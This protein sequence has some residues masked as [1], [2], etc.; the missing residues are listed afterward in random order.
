MF[1]GQFTY[2]YYSTILLDAHCSSSRRIILHYKQCMD[3]I[4]KLC[5]PLKGG[6]NIRQGIGSNLP[7][8]PLQQEI[9]GFIM[10]LNHYLPNYCIDIT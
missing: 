8:P 6:G 7:P 5:K 10:F 3:P 1:R 4:C 2:V 9:S